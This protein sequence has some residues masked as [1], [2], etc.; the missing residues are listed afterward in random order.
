[1]EL[2][3]SP[4]QDN[5]LSVTGQLMTHWFLDNNTPRWANEIHFS[6]KSLLT[7]S[8]LF[9]VE[10]I[11]DKMAQEVC[12]CFRSIFRHPWQSWKA[13]LL[14]KVEL[15]NWY[16]QKLHS[17][18]EDQGLWEIGTYKWGSC[19]QCWGTC[20]KKKFFSF[21]KY[22]Q[23]IVRSYRS[24]DVLLKCEHQLISDA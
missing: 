18:D 4:Q 19:T 5:V 20:R 3:Q 24:V 12:T 16:N 9:K 21:S 2:L 14:D 13:S 23:S 6:M 15:L 7:W 10:E 11:K 1:M 8:F 22:S 17:E